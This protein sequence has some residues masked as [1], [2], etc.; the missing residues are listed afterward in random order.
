MDSVTRAIVACALLFTTGTAFADI[1]SVAR[2][3]KTGEDWE[4]AI[5]ADGAHVYAL[6]PHYL[7]TAL[8]DTAAGFD[9]PYGDY[10]ETVTDGSGNFFSIWAEGESLI[11]TG[12]VYAAKC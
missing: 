4:P 2:G 11:G 8:H 1:S 10:T 7:P 6:W 9:H 5:L 3:D 12:D